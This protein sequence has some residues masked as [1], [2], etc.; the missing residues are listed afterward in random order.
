[1][2]NTLLLANL[3]GGYSLEALEV[4]DDLAK[5]LKLG[6]YQRLCHIVGNHLL[7]CWTV[8]NLNVIALYQI[9][10][11][12]VLDVEVSCMLSRACFSI[13]FKLHRACNILTDN[14]SVDF[15]ILSF[16]E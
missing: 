13:L 7:S 1:L 10:D 9:S 8:L 11:V 5:S 15:D 4:H 3:G 2:S 12:E 14:I 6:S 16:N